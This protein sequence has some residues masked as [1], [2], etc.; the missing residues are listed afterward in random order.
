MNILDQNT[1]ENIDAEKVRAAFNLL[2]DAG[3]PDDTI[4]SIRYELEVDQCSNCKKVWP[5]K[6][7]PIVC[8]PPWAFRHRRK[9]T[10][11]NGWY[12]D[13][14]RVKAA[15]Y[16]P[17]SDEGVS[18]PLQWNE[19]HTCKECTLKVAGIIGGYIAKHFPRKTLNAFLRVLLY[20]V[21][22]QRE[23]NKS[24][25]KHERHY[26]GYVAIVNALMQNIEP[27]GNKIAVTTLVKISSTLGLL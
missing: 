23:E 20:T 18:P 7:S 22:R 17:S 11:P 8:L 15:L 25:W 24:D 10:R 3:L 12:P 16:P 13:V 19:M 2:K 14:R 1:V 5:R 4:R 6:D 21:A 27:E 9:D 26:D